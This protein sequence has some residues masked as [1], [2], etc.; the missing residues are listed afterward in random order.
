MRTIVS[1]R[2]KLVL[3]FM[4]KMQSLQQQLQELETAL[5]RANQL[6]EEYNRR[7]QQVVQANRLARLMYATQE[8]DAVLLIAARSLSRIFSV[9]YYSLLILSTEVDG[10]RV[11]ADYRPAEDN[12]V[13]VSKQRVEDDSSLLRQL[14]AQHQ[15]KLVTVLSD[16]LL[17][18][19]WNQGEK[20][21][22][23][24]AL[25]VPLMS[26]TGIL[27]CL[28]LGS[29]DGAESFSNWERQLAQSVAGQIATAL[30]SVQTLDRARQVD[31]LELLNDIGQAV[32]LSYNLDHAL[33]QVTERLARFLS[34]SDAV[35]LLWQQDGHFTCRPTGRYIRHDFRDIS[36]YHLQLLT[37]EK[38]TELYQL[39][40]RGVTMVYENI[41]HDRTVPSVLRRLLK[42]W[43]WESVIAVG[44]LS[45]AKLVATLML[46]TQRE[47]HTFSPEDIDAVQACTSHIAAVL[48]R[49]HLEECQRAMAETRREPEEK[50]LNAQRLK[51][52]YEITQAINS[53]LDW[54]QVTDITAKILNKLFKV[55]AGSLL[56]WNEETNEMTF[57]MTLNEPP[58]GLTS[59]KLKM[60]QGIAGWVMQTGKPECVNDVRADS[61]FYSEIDQKGGFETRSILCVPIVKKTQTIGVLELINKLDGDFTK[62]E[63][64][65]LASIAASISTALDNA[66]LYHN[67]EEMLEK[68]QHM[69]EKLVD[70][71]RKI[72]EGQFALSIAS[73]IKDPV[74]LIQGSLSLAL[75]RGGRGSELE[76]YINLCMQETERI[77]SIVEW[78]SIYSE[79]VP[80]DR[81]EEVEYEIPE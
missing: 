25:L 65:L 71:E 45:G 58:E 50:S 55:E 6:K 59:F 3:R 22:I 38:L 32:N 35:V 52:L 67:L 79:V 46:G 81:R 36:N 74:Q 64:T 9:D 51:L 27:G 68:Q 16:E 48:Y 47:G 11:I 44:V 66:R 61:R 49:Q 15:S 17:T 13:Q 53:S 14:L 19:S 40:Q 33:N 12:R 69:Q 62:E 5:D 70:A 37:G 60:G 56:L 20:A 28:R 54:K 80:E 24:C 63:E 1:S 77:V 30:D 2:H 75:E 4:G 39:F 18:A 41:E 43:R 7:G 57:E 73:E 78:L 23:Q 21:D 34:M 31:R 26:G 29:S 8:Y 10:R 42:R 76:R 72:A